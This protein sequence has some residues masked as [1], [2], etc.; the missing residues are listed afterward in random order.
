MSELSFAHLNAL[1]S[2]RQEKD[3]HLLLLPQKPLA[4]CQPKQKGQSFGL[5]SLLSAL[6]LDPSSVLRWVVF[7]GQILRQR[8]AVSRLDLTVSLAVEGL[9]VMQG[10]EVAPGRLRLQ[11]CVLGVGFP[12]L[13]PP[14]LFENQAA[15]LEQRFSHFSAPGPKLFLHP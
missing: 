6:A 2:H 11:G 1:I 13:A 9:H 3:V 4:L 8:A 12:L 5:A 15:R 14:I 10:R 7:R